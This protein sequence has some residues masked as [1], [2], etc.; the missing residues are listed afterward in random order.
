MTSSAPAF[1]F[2]RDLVQNEEIRVVEEAA[3][4]SLLTTPL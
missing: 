3:E 4:K 2:A 1:E